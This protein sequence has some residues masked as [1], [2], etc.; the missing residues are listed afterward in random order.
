MIVYAAPDDPMR[1]KNRGFCFLQYDEHK[2]ASSAKKK[3][4]SGRVKP[5]NCELVVDWAE[6]QEEP[7][8]EI[9]SKVIEQT[10]KIE[11][12]E[13]LVFCR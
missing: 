1:K 5:W 7:D 9:M 3:L 6:Q 8:D 10:V 13:I 12:L 2:N 4:S 11:L